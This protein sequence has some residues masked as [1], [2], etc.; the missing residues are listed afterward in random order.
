MGRITRPPP[1]PRPK[2]VHEVRVRHTHRNQPWFLEQLARVAGTGGYRKRTPFWA[3]TIFA[4]ARRFR[5][6]TLTF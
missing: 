6:T 4:L 3:Y 2:F 1:K 5:T